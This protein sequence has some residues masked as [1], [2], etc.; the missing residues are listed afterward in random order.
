MY[1]SG[2]INTYR[3]GKMAYNSGFVLTNIGLRYRHRRKA[4]PSVYTFSDLARNS[5]YERIMEADGLSRLVGDQHDLVADRVHLI[6]AV[7][8]SGMVEVWQ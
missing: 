2:N 1:T 6:D 8:C 4:V 7:L 5:G 3:Q